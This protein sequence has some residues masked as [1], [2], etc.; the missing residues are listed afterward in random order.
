MKL[1]MP[2]PIPTLNKKQFKNHANE[3][4]NKKEYR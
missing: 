1:R 4:D 2:K 3:V